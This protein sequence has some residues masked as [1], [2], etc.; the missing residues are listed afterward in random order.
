MSFEIEREA[1]YP[2]ICYA[3]KRISLL[4]QHG[5]ERIMAPLL[6]AALGC[7]VEH[8]QG[9]DTNL[10]GTFTREVPRADNQL[11]TARTKARIGMDISG[12]PLGL[13]SERSFGPDPFTGLMPWNIEIVLLIDDEAQMEILGEAQGPGNH[14]QL[15]ASSWEEV[16]NFAR[17]V[18]FPRQFL[19]LRPGNSD[20][21]RIQKGLSNWDA[22]EKAYQT[23]AAQSDSRKVFLETDGRAYG[24]PMRMEMIWKATADLLRRIQSRCPNCEAPGFIRAHLLPG[25][26]CRWCGSPTRIQNRSGRNM[27]LPAMWLHENHSL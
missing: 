6:E 7:R 10:L 8:V 13:A 15:L 21:E 16:E 22:L 17:I 18:D 3:D 25:L 5:K 14:Q 20:D 26:P 12:L 4:T 2:P 23:A 9:Y 11:A 19:I 27:G 24:N 1:R